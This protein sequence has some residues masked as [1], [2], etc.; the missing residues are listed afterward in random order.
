MILPEKIMAM[1]ERMNY[2]VTY[3]LVTFVKSVATR[4]FRVSDLFYVSVAGLSFSTTFYGVYEHRIQEG[5]QPKSHRSLYFV[6]D[7]LYYFYAILFVDMFMT[8]LRDPAID[9][10]DTHKIS[11][12]WMAAT[13]AVF[14]VAVVCDVCTDAFGETVVTTNLRRLVFFMYAENSVLLT[15][16]AEVDK[17][18]PLTGM[19]CL[20]YLQYGVSVHSLPFTVRVFMQAASMIFTNVVVSTTLKTNDTST[21]A[22]LEI[23]WLLSLLIVFSATSDTLFGVGDL[24][25]YATWKAGSNITNF[26]SYQGF[27][28]LD[29]FVGTVLVLFVFKVISLPHALRHTEF[30]GDISALVSVNVCLS[31]LEK[32]FRGMP[33]DVL[34]MFL[35]C[36]LVAVHYIVTVAR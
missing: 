5:C 17:V 2:L 25:D 12:C 26:L 28:D 22:S 9:S 33:Y 30:L 1:F 13:S 15:R 29:V 6:L 8:A 31:V 20:L 7:T 34:W 36:I 27:D 10:V 16:D 23:M 11:M 24:R 18:I 3:S 35:L 32:L 4:F 14:V 19:L 21:D